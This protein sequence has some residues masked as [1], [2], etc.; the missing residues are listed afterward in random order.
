MDFRCRGGWPLMRG[1]SGLGGANLES[2]GVGP[3]EFN[4]LA[5]RKGDARAINMSVDRQFTPAAI[6]QYDQRDR[7]RPPIIEYLVH[8]GTHRTAGEQNVIDQQQM[9]ISDV[10]RQLRWFDGWMN[11]DATEIVAIEGDVELAQPFGQP[12]PVVES[13][14]DPDAARVYADEGR[15]VEPE[16][17]SP[18]YEPCTDI[19]EQGVD[20]D[21]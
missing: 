9:P 14:R 8:G 11:A 18:L 19:L 10:E 21:V 7:A 20:F 3:E 4:M 13:F 1:L 12:E 16:L 15:I 2:Q 5:V 17:S 6:D